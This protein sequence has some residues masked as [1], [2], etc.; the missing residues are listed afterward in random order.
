MGGAVI[1]V[2]GNEKVRSRQDEMETFQW[3]HAH[4]KNLVD[5]FQ[6]YPNLYDTKHKCKNQDQTEQ[7]RRKIAKEIGN[8]C[9]GDPFDTLLVRLN[10]DNQGWTKNLGGPSRQ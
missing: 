1:H 4:T 7:A 2:V 8:G 5:L 10:T 3:T 6:T 9:C